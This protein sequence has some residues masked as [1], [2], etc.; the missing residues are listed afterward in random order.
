[1]I[2]FAIFVS[3][4]FL[5]SLVS[6]RLNQTIVTAPIVFTLTGLLAFPVFIQTGLDMNFDVFLPPAEL[7]LVFLLF[8]GTEL[9]AFQGVGTL[10]FRLLSVGMPLTILLGAIVAWA[11]FRDLSIWEAAI[12]GA[13]LAP[14]D[15]GLGQH[16]V[17]SQR[18]PMHIR[19]ALN[20]EAGLNDGLAV[21]FLLFFIAIAAAGTLI[22]EVSLTRLI[23][24]QLGLGV[25]I[26]AGIGLA[27][28]K[29]VQLARR[30]EWITDSFQQ[31]GIVALPLFCFVLSEMLNASMFI[32]AFVAGLAVQIGL[33]KEHDH[34][35]EFTQQ[36]GKVLNLL[37][38]FLFGLLVGRDLRLFNQ[39]SALYAVFSLTLVRMIPVAIAL[40]G[41]HLSKPTVIF[42]GWFGP[43]GLASIVLGLIYLEKEI[44]LPGEPTI[45]LAVM[46]TVL[47][48]I[49]AHGLSSGPG[50]GLY[51]RN[52]AL[53]DVTTPE[54]QE[55][56][57]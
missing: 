25:L 35:F 51:A 8:A 6:R 13:I 47:V 18:V 3:V 7:G 19:Q 49:F 55:R 9:S 4:L 48:S 12:L 23:F 52:V 31:I 24:E 14:T 56:K 40:A 29:L 30:K 43:R 16:I 46:A 32:A 39:V 54:R 42:L 2:P 44:H 22:N 10:P 20:I 53:L 11:L 26:G 33:K 28:G 50:I 27:G 45:R 41:A 38:F 34:S 1:M 21:P 37:I 5:Y 17:N 15:A 57:E 36:S